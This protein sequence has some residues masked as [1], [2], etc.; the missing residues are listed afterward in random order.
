M[1]NFFR[2]GLTTLGLSVGFLGASWLGAGQLA[3]AATLADRGL[4]TPL[5][6]ANSVRWVPIEAYNGN[7]ETARFKGD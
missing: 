2:T 3:Q 6:Q 4:P 1:V 5:T 7:P